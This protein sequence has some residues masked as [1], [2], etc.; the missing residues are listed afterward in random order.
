MCDVRTYLDFLSVH[1][2]LYE[3]IEK[4]GTKFKISEINDAITYAKSGKNV[5]TLLVK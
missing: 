3:K 5:K 4:L 1:T 2:E